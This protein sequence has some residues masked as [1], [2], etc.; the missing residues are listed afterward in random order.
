MS[1]FVCIKENNSGIPPTVE[2]SEGSHLKQTFLHVQYVTDYVPTPHRGRPRPQSLVDM[3]VLVLRYPSTHQLGHDSHSFLP[4]A[5]TLE[6]GSQIQSIVT[7]NG[8]LA[9]GSYVIL[10]LAFNHYQHLLGTSRGRERER[11]EIGG[12]E[13]M[14]DGTSA[15]PY[16]VAVFSARELAYE[17]VVTRPGFLSESLFLL[18]EKTGK[19]S[20]VG[21]GMDLSV[22]AFIVMLLMFVC[23]TV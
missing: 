8:F 17:S 5:C 3:A 22:N 23:T 12:R 21:R 13:E 16:V 7:T 10:P 19:V 4:I 20:Q 2:L 18:A 14:E 9:P 11:E 1:Q 15:I 6:S